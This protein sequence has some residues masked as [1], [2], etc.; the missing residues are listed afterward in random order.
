M[1]NKKMIWVG[2]GFFLIVFL[3]W[4][5]GNEIPEGIDEDYYHYSIR[6]MEEL[7]KNYEENEFPSDEVISSITDYSESMEIHPEEYTA[8]EI[9]VMDNLRSIALNIGII[10]TSD[11]AELLQEDVETYFKNLEVL[12]EID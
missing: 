6:A 7:E 8:K 1:N 3:I 2:I 12:L 4:G 11:N 10:S 5:D 9:Y